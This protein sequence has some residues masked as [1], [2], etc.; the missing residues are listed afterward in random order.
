MYILC[1]PKLLQMLTVQTMQFY[2]EHAGISK[3]AS[4]NSEPFVCWINNA[5]SVNIYNMYL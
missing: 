2:I 1:L 4:N 3:T 5:H